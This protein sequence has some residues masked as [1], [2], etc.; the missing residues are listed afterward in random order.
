MWAGQQAGQLVAVDPGRSEDA[1]CA[2][3]F[4]TVVNAH[5]EVCAVH[6][7]DGC[8]LSADQVRPVGEN[9]G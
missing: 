2:A 1:A 5:G 6:K 4:N 8:P 3:H 9:S 7:A